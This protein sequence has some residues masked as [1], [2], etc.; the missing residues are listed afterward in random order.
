MY[1]AI[2]ISLPWLLKRVFLAL[3][4]DVAESSLHPGKQRACEAQLP[5]DIGRRFTK[6]AMGFTG[7]I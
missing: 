2:H 1:A 4:P 6:P 3:V 5:L 7:H